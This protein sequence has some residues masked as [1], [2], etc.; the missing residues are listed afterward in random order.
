MKNYEPNINGLNKRIRLINL[1][2]FA[3]FAPLAP[4]LRK[5]LAELV[6]ERNEKLNAWTHENALSVFR[7]VKAN[8][9]KAKV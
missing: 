3:P 8:L 7:F 5:E 2:L 4:E 6:A 9:R 1:Q